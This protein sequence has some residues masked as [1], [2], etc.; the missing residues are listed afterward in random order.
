MT[1]IP[2]LL[3]KV[4]LFYGISALLG[5]LTPKFLVWGLVVGL[6]TKVVTGLTPTLAMDFQEMVLNPLFKFSTAYF[7]IMWDVMM[8]TFSNE[9]LVV[10]IVIGCLFAGGGLMFIVSAVMGV[11]TWPELLIARGLVGVIL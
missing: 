2:D 11:L 8:T 4:V 7:S 9:S 6:G 3:V 10:S 5:Y 1:A